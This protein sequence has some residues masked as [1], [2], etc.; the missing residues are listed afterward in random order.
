MSA[1]TLG[2]GADPS[3]SLHEELVFDFAHVSS[4]GCAA[5][6]NVWG[7]AG[8]LGVS[9]SRSLKVLAEPDRLHADTD[10]I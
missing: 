7:V 3:W 5:T 4:F 2:D 8:G 6:E 10:D 1:S 9:T